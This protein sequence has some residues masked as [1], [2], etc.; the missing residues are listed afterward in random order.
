MKIKILAL[1]LTVLIISCKGTD[2]IVETTS[3]NT[4]VKHPKIEA[5]LLKMTLDEKIGQMNQYNG[6]WD[7][8][9]PTPANG[10]ASMKYQ[11]IK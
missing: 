7:L 3:N 9:G 4:P 8:T 1:I 2:K 6:F 10:D 11:H 5:L